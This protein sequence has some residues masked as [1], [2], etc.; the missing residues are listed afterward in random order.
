MIRTSLV[1][2]MMTNDSFKAQG[3]SI[4]ENNSAAVGIVLLVYLSIFILQR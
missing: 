3:L 4:C 2:P 1:Q